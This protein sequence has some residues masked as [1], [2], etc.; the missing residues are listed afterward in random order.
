M[1]R[2]R[3]RWADDDTL[4]SNPTMQRPR[5]YRRRYE[6][7]CRLQMV[8]AR[9]AVEP[10]N[11]QPQVAGCIHASKR[12]YRA[13]SDHWAFSDWA[14][15]DWAAVRPFVRN[16]R[17]TSNPQCR[18]RYHARRPNWPSSCKVPPQVLQVTNRRSLMISCPPFSVSRTLGKL[19]ALCTASGLYKGIQPHACIPCRVPTALTH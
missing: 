6:P 17:D 15:V 14:A 2:L 18:Q 16:S 10:D 5:F 13:L 3:L 8:K 9:I 11:P 19:A 7:T 1:S 12:E 4:T